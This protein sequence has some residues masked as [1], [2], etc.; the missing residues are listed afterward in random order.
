MVVFLKGPLGYFST[1]YPIGSFFYY[2]ESQGYFQ[3]E[4]IFKGGIKG[5]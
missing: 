1:Y 4:K 5:T 3:L 2:M